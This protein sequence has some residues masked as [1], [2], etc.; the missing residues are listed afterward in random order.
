[1][2]KQRSPNRDK[3][4]EIY[5]DANG[6]ITPKEIA[7][8]LNENVA[9]IRTWKSIDKWDIKLGFKRNK[10]GAPKGNKNAVGN[11]GGAPKGNLN[12]MDKGQSI[13]YHR[14]SSKEFLMKYVPKATAKLIDDMFNSDITGLDMLWMNILSQ[15]SNIIRMQSIMNVSDREDINKELKKVSVGNVE[16]EEWIIQFADDRQAKYSKALSDSVRTLNKLINDYEEL[17]NKNWDTATEEQKLR[18]EKLKVEVAKI[19]DNKENGK[20]NLNKLMEVFKK[21][22]VE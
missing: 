5:R 15:Q 6:S 9:N 19:N 17:L 21:G 8:K 7:D 22:P 4:F 13:A 10:K 1:M 20:G 3:S 18:I 2:S 12:G 14:F 11:N 16:T